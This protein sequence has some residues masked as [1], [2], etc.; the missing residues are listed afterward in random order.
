MYE[1]RYVAIAGIWLAG[2]LVLAQAVS[3]EEIVA[4]SKANSSHFRHWDR[5]PDL[6]E[7]AN[8]LGKD[9]SADRVI[10]GTSSLCD[11]CPSPD[12]QND[13][14][15]KR[16]THESDVVVIG[17]VRRNVSAFTEHNA[18]VFTDSQF[19]V[20]EIWK[21]S[22][23]HPTVVGQEIT[24]ARPGGTV[25]SGEHTIRAYPSNQVPLQ[26][27]RTYLMYLNYLFDSNSYVPVTL[28]GFDVTGLAVIPL[29]SSELPPAER[30]LSN[31]PQF[32]KAMQASTMRGIEEGK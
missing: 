13:P 15:V 26:V 7:R 24:I 3:D 21:N 25:Q 27:G 14:A 32:L 12:P 9:I 5:G 16:A 1:N 30:L 8:S 31:K 22:A 19:V 10:T 18:F 2:H 29:R 23:D 4:R 6:K 28:D 20:G 17:Q 11:G